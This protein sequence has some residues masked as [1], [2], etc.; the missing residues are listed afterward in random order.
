MD[1][2][3]RV[4]IV[5]TESRKNGELNEV[6]NEYMNIFGMLMQNPVELGDYGTEGIDFSDNQTC[7]DYCHQ[8]QISNSRFSTMR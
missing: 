5:F 3:K 1:R 6:I 7:T 4:K 8:D 2:M